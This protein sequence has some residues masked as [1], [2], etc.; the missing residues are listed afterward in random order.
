[1]DG[2][3]QPL[4]S[5]SNF[6]VPSGCTLSWPPS[7]ERSPPSAA[8]ACQLVMTPLPARCAPQVWH[9]EGRKQGGQAQVRARDP[10]S[11][12]GRQHAARPWEVLT[13]NQLCLRLHTQTASQSRV[14]SSASRL[15]ERLPPTPRCVNSGS[16]LAP[17]RA[18]FPPGL[19]SRKY[20]LL[21]ARH[22]RSGSCRHSPYCQG[23]TIC[24]QG[25]WQ[26]LILRPGRFGPFHRLI[27]ILPVT[28]VYRREYDNCG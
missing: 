2:Y 15:P 18:C 11:D 10:P 25:L 5:G 26:R 4:S 27:F 23:R 17:P 19:A 24:Q 28:D 8:R 14:S 7:S 6:S 21:S 1:M 22:L 9:N 20:L 16:P 12:Q 13:R 3:C